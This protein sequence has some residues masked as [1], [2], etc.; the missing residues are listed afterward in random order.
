MKYT[1]DQVLA[2]DAAGLLS[3]AERLR[4]VA[5]GAVDPENRLRAVWRNLPLQWRGGVSQP[6][7]SAKLDGAYQAARLVVTRLHAGVAE[8]QQFAAAVLTAQ[9]ELTDVKDQATAN[10]LT[11]A[12]NG[13]VAAPW[14]GSRNFPESLWSLPDYLHRRNVA[15]ALQQRFRAALAALEAADIAAAARLTDMSDLTGTQR[16][17]GPVDP[18]RVARAQESV[19]RRSSG[20]DSS[21]L[22]G[23]TAGEVNAVAAGLSNGELAAWNQQIAG[24]PNQ[25]RVAIANVLL[26][27]ADRA[28]LARLQQ[29]MPALA[30]ALL[31]H[32]GGRALRFGS[33]GALLAVDGVQWYTDSHQGESGDCYFISS[34]LAAEQASPGFILDHIRTNPNGTHTVT[35]YDEKGN[36]APVVVDDRLPLSTDP[37]RPQ[38][39]GIIDKSVAGDFRWSGQFTSVPDTRS[40]VISADDQETWMAVYEKALAQHRTGTYLGVTEGLPEYGLQTITGGAVDTQWH[41][42]GMPTNTVMFLRDR[43]AKGQAVTGS[44][45]Y[46]LLPG[47]VSNDDLLSGHSYVVTGVR[48][49]GSIRVA[50]PTGGISRKAEWEDGKGFWVKPDL[51]TRHFIRFDAADPRRGSR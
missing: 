2:W 18:G 5:H 35:L 17:D 40:G 45:S 24:L 39:G 13:T 48:D 49:D 21:L 43:L 22:R 28:Q 32:P 27:G 15:T 1:I 9:R 47:R 3:D 11:I 6:V 4:V 42:F 34:L 44:T 16:L 46:N 20:G 36:P 38:V 25:E 10:H 41:D 12:N 30:P 37:E 50:D 29:H 19:R 8:I 51:V 26:A 23:L 31:D 7:V 33:T 14:I